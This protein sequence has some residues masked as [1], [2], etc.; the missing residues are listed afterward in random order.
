MSGRPMLRVRV[1]RSTPE[2]WFGRPL[3]EVHDAD[4]WR[5]WA[6]VQAAQK[7]EERLARG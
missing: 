1:L 2:Q 4:M 3:R 6:C 7:L 5:W